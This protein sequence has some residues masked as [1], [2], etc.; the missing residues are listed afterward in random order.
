MTPDAASSHNFN[1]GSGSWSHACA[2]A[3]RAL[4]VGVATDH[5][6]GITVS[7][8]TY[9]GVAMTPVGTH[10][11]SGAYRV[12][13]FRLLAPAT[14]TNTVAVTLSG[15]SAAVCAAISLTGVDQTD[16]DDAPV[17]SDASSGHPSST[18]PSATGDLV[19]Q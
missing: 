8:V 6:A 17:T 13:V 14:G 3:D 16:P 5:N 2:G 7:G 19:L 1:A 18:V 15:S 10:F 12:T 9:G 11:R 4:Y